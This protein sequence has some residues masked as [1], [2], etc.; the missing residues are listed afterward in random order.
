[1]QSK[2]LIGWY[3]VKPKSGVPL[4]IQLCIPRITIDDCEFVI[5]SKSTM[6]G[7][8]ET[9]CEVIEFD[10]IDCTRE[11]ESEN[12]GD[13]LSTAP[14]SSGNTLSDVNAHIEHIVLNGRSKWSCKLCNAKKVKQIC[15]YP[16]IRLP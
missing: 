9:F 16:M 10:D 7:H 13:L 3:A 11:Y 12:K 15:S 1:M 4:V 6:P 2:I 5:D 14:S 8:D